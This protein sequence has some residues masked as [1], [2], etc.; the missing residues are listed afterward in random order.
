M[1]EQDKKE[2]LPE[3]ELETSLPEG[4]EGWQRLQAELAQAQAKAEEYRQQ[5]LH[6][7]ADFD[8]W[9]KRLLQEQ[10][11]NLRLA[12]AELVQ[13]LLP[14]LDD[15]ERALAAPGEQLEDFLRG[16]AMIYQRLLEILGQEGLEPIVAQ[17][18]PFDPTCHEAFAFAETGEGPDGIILEE[19]RRGYLFRGKLL[20]P[21]L[22]KVARQKADETP[23]KEED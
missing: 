16:V 23:T 22:V 6:L 14:V 9:R 3:E 5:L 15:L 18:Q 10:E 19:Y 4:E 12:G 20:R 11:E 1:E 2:K 13:R 8:N 17:G 7:R 21:S